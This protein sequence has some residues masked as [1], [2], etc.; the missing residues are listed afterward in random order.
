M[1]E[2]LQAMTCAALI[3]CAYTAVRAVLALFR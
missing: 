3:G 1:I 2:L